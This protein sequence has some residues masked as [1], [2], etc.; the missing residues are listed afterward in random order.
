MEPFLFKDS[1]GKKSTTTTAFIF[2]TAIV[3]IKLIF[4]GMTIYGF[5]FEKFSGSDYGMAV[6][7]LGAILVLNNKKSVSEKKEEK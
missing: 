6:A 5:V 2:G 7:A 4:S 1:S 3:N